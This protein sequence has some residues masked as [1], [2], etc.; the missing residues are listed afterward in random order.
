MALKIIVLVA[1]AIGLCALM[2]ILTFKDF[3]E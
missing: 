2:I 3:I 1:L